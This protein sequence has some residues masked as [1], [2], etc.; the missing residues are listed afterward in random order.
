MRSLARLLG[1]I[2]LAA[3]C[4]TTRSHDLRATE[5]VALADGGLAFVFDDGRPPAP[6]FVQSEECA[7]DAGAFL[8]LLSSRDCQTDADCRVYRHGLGVADLDVCYP[9]RV[10][11]I[12]SQELDREYQALAK[13]C[14]HATVFSM[15][16]CSRASCIHNRCEI[17][18]HLA[19][20]T[21]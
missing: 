8:R 21:P 9:A 7:A 11:V 12:E 15:Q 6:T 4:A 19:P 13:I 3:A 17:A 5:P 18:R 20:G 1:A 16:S 10:D 14:G 2:V